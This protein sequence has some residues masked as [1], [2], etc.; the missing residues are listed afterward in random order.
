MRATTPS[1]PEIGTPER[2][3]FEQRLRADIGDEAFKTLQ[4][5][6][7]SV[8]SP[9]FGKALAANLAGKQALQNLGLSSVFGSEFTGGTAA[10]AGNFLRALEI[11][12]PVGGHITENNDLDALLEE[13]IS[14]I[15][16]DNPTQA[17]AAMSRANQLG[18]NATNFHSLVNALA[19]GLSSEA[20]AKYYDPE[21][22]Y[23]KANSGR[24]LPGSLS[25]WFEGQ[26]SGWAGVAV[27]K[28]R[29]GYTDEQIAY[30]LGRPISDVQAGLAPF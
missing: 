8:L 17:A 20:Y 15:R 14:N 26:S 18:V 28:A 3:A 27:E 6:P 12:R 9:T 4:A 7:N 22:A 11:E 23:A 19:P 21:S 2:A 29:H 24:G 25:T 30:A 16:G 13:Y 1:V 5:N 10:D